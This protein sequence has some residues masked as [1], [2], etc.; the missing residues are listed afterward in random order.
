MSHSSENIVV[1]FGANRIN[2]NFEFIERKGIGHPDTLSDHLAE[3]LS[4][5]YS[6]ETRRRFGAILHHNFDKVGLLGGKSFVAFGDGHM[7]SPVRVL[8]NGRVSTSFAGEQIDTEDLIRST[9]KR[10]FNKRFGDL[11]R[12][13]D[14]VFHMN[15]SNGSS[16]GKTDEANAE[17]GS[18]KYWFEPR[19][20]Q[21]LHELTH[22]HAN[23][24]SL[25]CGYAPFSPL[26][27][28]VLA[29]EGLL[30]SEEYKKAHAWCGNDIKVMANRIGDNVDIT[31]CVP[32]IA[33]HVSNATEYKE[34]LE[35]VRTD[36]EQELEKFFGKNFTLHLNT[37]DNFGTGQ[38]YLTAT[39]SS[40]ES[41]DEGL[42]GRGNRINGLIANNRPMSMEGANGKNPVYHVGK[43]YNIAAFR[44]AK[45]IYE[46]T[47]SPAEVFFVSQTGQDLINPWKAYVKL[48]KKDTPIEGVAGIVRAQLALIPQIT[49]ELLRGEIVLA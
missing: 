5:E 44:T 41:G 29:V 47:G 35:L 36:L 25:G 31:M 46:E 16:N 1:E 48:D 18:R 30:N 2:D 10:F 49:E 33:N 4:R 38:L 3:T 14:L 40:I 17:K 27:Q 28:A 6:N 24:T 22:L 32:Q 26:E 11:I 42:V 9:T 37:R 7:T 8:I 13:E 23:D 21:D 15:L 19:G 34:N 43:L 45:A 12:P 20:L 39:G